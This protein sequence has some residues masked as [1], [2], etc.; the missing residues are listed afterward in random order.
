M[1]K[2]AIVAE[3]VLPQNTWKLRKANETLRIVGVPSGI[4]TANFPNT[5][6]K[7]YRL[8]QLLRRSSSHFSVL[9]TIGYFKG[10]HSCLLDKNHTLLNV[11]F[12]EVTLRSKFCRG[13][14]SDR[15]RNRK[16]KNPALAFG[17]DG[18]DAY[19]AK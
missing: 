11:Q 15:V 18:S 17:S 1:R 14:P 4:Q 8:G 16:S 9:I 19:D 7:H 6:H 5:S 3:L 2:E 13:L 10:S 12:K